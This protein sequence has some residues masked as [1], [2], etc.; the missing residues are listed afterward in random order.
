MGMFCFFIVVVITQLHS[1]AKIPRMIYLRRVNCIIYKLCLTKAS[2]KN[3]YIYTFPNLLKALEARTLW[4]TSEGNLTFIGLIKKVT[5]RL[6]QV[7]IPNVAWVCLDPG[8][9]R[10]HQESVLIISCLFF[11]F[12]DFTPRQSLPS[13]WQDGS[14]K[15]LQAFQ[16]RTKD[17]LLLNHLN[18][19]HTVHSDTQWSGRGNMLVS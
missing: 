6:L 8:I 3:I 12:E 7:K 10:T 18:H 14:W 16:Q 13:W 2:T 11:I 17:W 1:F 9:Q 19:S 5:H 15:P 4:T